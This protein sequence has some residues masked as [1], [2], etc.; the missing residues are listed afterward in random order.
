MSMEKKSLFEIGILSLTFLLFMILSL[1]RFGVS[2]IYGEIGIMFGVFF[3]SVSFALYSLN[4]KLK[5]SQNIFSKSI[6]SILELATN[7]VI[8]L[9]LFLIVGSMLIG[10]Y[11]EIGWGFFLLFPFFIGVE[12]TGLIIGIILGLILKNKGV[13]EFKINF[14]NWVII[15]IFLIFFGFFFFYAI[16]Y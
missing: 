7:L 6:F 16:F 11:G 15:S 13:L 1:L 10:G 14:W 3:L 5:R 9:F 8:L 4:W 2:F 12:L